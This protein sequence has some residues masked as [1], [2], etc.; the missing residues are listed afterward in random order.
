ML[1]VGELTSILIFRATELYTKKVGERI[2][3]RSHGHTVLAQAKALLTL[4][5]RLA[6]IGPVDNHENDLSRVALRVALL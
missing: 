4:V 3:E 2:G 6:L 5:L 1:P